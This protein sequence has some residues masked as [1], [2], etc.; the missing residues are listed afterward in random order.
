[1]SE[2]DEV[3]VKAIGSPTKTR[4]IEPTSTRTAVSRPDYH[5]EDDR[6][7]VV[8]GQPTQDSI[9]GFAS[10]LSF[11]YENNNDHGLDETEEESW[12]QMRQGLP[13]GLTSSCLQELGILKR[14]NSTDRS[15]SGKRRNGSSANAT[16]DDDAQD[17][18]GDDIVILAQRD[19][20]PESL[21]EAP[22]SL[23][24]PSNSFQV[25]EAPEYTFALPDRTRQ[26]QLIQPSIQ[27]ESTQE[28]DEW[29]DPRIQ[30]GQRSVQGASI[31][32]HQPS[33]PSPPSQT[34][35]STL[36]TMPTFPNSFPREPQ[37]SYEHEGQEGEE[38]LARDQDQSP[39][40]EH[41]HE[42][43]QDNH[44]QKLS[45]PSP[46]SQTSFSILPT[47]PTFPSELDS[48]PSVIVID[49]QTPSQEDE[50]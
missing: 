20:F 17:G 5:E 22:A 1:M 26:D 46:P 44:S 40:Q 29:G 28:L 2:V 45:F 7:T 30:P 50:L 32:Y 39:T 36:P 24:F 23:S 18:D 15:D 27:S 25:L 37:A 33:F 41:H 49:S 11:A 9:T 4:T 42:A 10:L 6:S 13:S 43:N 19:V 35:F 47:M 31:S 12:S 16:Q 38:A 14:K 21:G 34:S 3:Q 48:Q 8:G